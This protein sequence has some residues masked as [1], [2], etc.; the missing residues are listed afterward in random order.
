MKTLLIELK[1]VSTELIILA[2]IAAVLFV[3]Q[4]DI[5][6]QG[7]EL[8]LFKMLLV[9]AG[10]LHAHIIRKVAFGYINFRYSADSMHKALIVAL[11]VVI[12]WSYARGG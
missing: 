12:I 3:W 9:S 11:Y 2:I 10:F 4:F 5:Q 8:L 6:R 1:R 7:L